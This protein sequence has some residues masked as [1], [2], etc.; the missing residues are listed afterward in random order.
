[1]AG[2]VVVRLTADREN[3][4]ADQVDELMS[5][6]IGYNK[7]LSS[8]IKEVRDTGQFNRAGLAEIDGIGAFS[9]SAEGSEEL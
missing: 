8:I 2:L 6:A 5:V 9:L 3:A 4:I 7:H 1:M